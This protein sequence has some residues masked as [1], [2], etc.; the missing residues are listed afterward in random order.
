MVTRTLKAI[1]YQ[2]KDAVETP[3]FEEPAGASPASV[4]AVAIP[5]AVPVAS[6]GPVA[7][8]EGVPSSLLISFTSLWLRS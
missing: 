1:Y 7:S 6:F 4:A 3:V 5:V 2:Y 8:I